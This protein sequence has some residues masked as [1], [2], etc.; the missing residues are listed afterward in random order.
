MTLD[1]A[2]IFFR[3]DKSRDKT[4]ID[5]WDYIKLKNCEI[6]ETAEQNGNLWNGRKYLQILCL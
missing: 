5:K 6:E 2:V 1:L 4:K 3:Y